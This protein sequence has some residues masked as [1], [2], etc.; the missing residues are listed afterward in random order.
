MFDGSPAGREV[1][2]NLQKIRERLQGFEF[3]ELFVEE[4][5]WANPKS[6]QPHALVVADNELA[7][8]RVAELDGA[9]VLRFEPLAGGIPDPGLRQKIHRAIQKH[10]HEHLL[11]FVD[12]SE[13]QCLWSWP[14]REDGKL[15]ARS[16][17]YMRSQPG[18][19]LIGKLG[20][21]HFELADFSDD[22][23]VGITNV[24]RRLESAF[25]VE[26][27]TKRF[28]QDFDNLRIGF[29]E[30]IEGIEDEK[31]RRWYVS[32]LLNRLMFIW[33]LQKKRFVDGDPDYLPNKL[34]QSRARGENRFYSEFLNALFF[35]GFARPPEKRS[36]KAGKLLGDIRYLNGGLF[37]RHPIE[38]R[39]PDIAIA[40]D[41]FEGLFQLF[42]RYTW[43][44][45]D[46][47]SGKD[48]EINP[49]VLGYIFEKYINDKAFGAYYTCSEITEYLCEQTIHRLLLHKVNE[50]RGGVPEA[51]VA[52][53]KAFDTLPELLLH[54]D[55]SLCRRLIMDGGILRE[56]SILDP[57][58]GSGAFLVAAMKTLIDVYAA[59]IGRIEVLGDNTLSQWLK[60]FRRE[61]PSTAYGIKKLIITDNLFGVDL[62]EEAGEICKLRLFLALVASAHKEEDLE[63]L[64]NIDFNILTGNSL[65]GMLRMGDE[66]SEHKQGN[67][68]AK[69]WQDVIEEYER[70]VEVYR[71]STS[72]AEDLQA[73]RDGIEALRKE[74][75]QGLN[76]LLLE[77]FGDIRY[78]QATWNESAGKLGRAR[79]RPLTEADMAALE[80][81]HWDFEFNR[82][83]RQGGFDVILANPPWEIVKPNDK[84]FFE[85]YSDLVTK[86]SMPIE[87]FKKHRAQCM[88]S[89][90]EIREGYLEY[91]S[92]YPHQS[93]W[94]LTASQ[95]ANQRSTYRDIGAGN[96]KKTGSDINLYKLFLEQCFNLLHEQGQCGI[97]IPS[98]I[99]TGLGAKGLRELLFEQT[100]VSGLFGFENRKAIFEG[101][102]RMFKFVVLTF[103]KGGATERFP[104][105]FMRHDVKELAEFPRSGALQMATA[106]IRKL[107]PAAYGLMEFRSDTD[108]AIA[109]KMTLPFPLLGDSVGA[110]WTARFHREFDMTNDSGLFHTRPGKSR[111]PL[112]EGKLIHQFTHLFAPDKLRYWVDEKAGRRKI[113]GRNAD[114]E[115]RLD[116]QEYRLG[117]RDVASNTN[118]RTLISTILPADVFLGNKVPALHI[119][120]D[121]VAHDADEKR[122]RLI[123]G[124]EQLFLCACWNSFV[125]DYLIRM[126]VT[127][128]LNFFYM[129]ELPIPRLT[130]ADPA[131]HPIVKRAARLI[132]TTPEFDTLASEVGLNRAQDA[133]TEPAERARL[134]AELDALV[135]HLYGLTEPEFIHILKA[136]PLVGAPEKTAAQNAYRDVERGGLE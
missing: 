67:L 4:L 66:Q 136:F 48:D 37:V 11:L 108:L 18:D 131:F 61:H 40:D 125:V 7:Y 35:E 13:T 30:K 47:P 52:G 116:Y 93:A 54:L 111:L 69:S 76:K 126:K 55:A 129:Y 77:R 100:T 12:E 130:D 51:G 101:V 41:A 109:E 133:A 71:H 134:R 132:C 16:H 73:Q 62:M 21:L 115:Q 31:D 28:Y 44:L 60:A 95:Y 120:E 26:R 57:A 112:Y 46:T 50:L 92:S 90:K 79:R 56:L 15:S 33:F 124:S 36:A 17:L 5:G 59:V 82:V 43:H 49:Q 107:S 34:Q 106:S 86:N 105:A 27:V 63:P 94:F 91:S 97:V 2:V 87:E 68:G 103:E 53:G 9:V 110:A 29:A 14:K 8:N 45:D 24:A 89:S 74:A 75:T 58:C 65:I 83:L 85:R 88:R 72:Y 81:F 104:A 22:G 127:T 99:Y 39:W 10:H 6:S 20:R 32:V 118:E 135:A 128:T 102:H 119:Y 3:T 70:K 19:L 23:N 98:D 42:A 78:E 114:K 1:A 64:P 96:L 25:D 80:P 84:E 122:E 121:A 117:F 123:K 113:L 38:E